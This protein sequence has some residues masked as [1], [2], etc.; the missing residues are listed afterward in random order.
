MTSTA[1]LISRGALPAARSCSGVTSTARAAVHCQWCSAP[2][3]AF[4][5]IWPSRHPRRLQSLF[6]PWA[7]QLLAVP[8]CRV[9]TGSCASACTDPHSRL[10]AAQAPFIAGTLRMVTPSTSAYMYRLVC[11]LA[12]PQHAGC[13]SSA[14]KPPRPPHQ[15]PPCSTHPVLPPVARQ[16]A[17]L[18]SPATSAMRWTALLSS[19]RCPLLCRAAA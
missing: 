17:P 5:S 9:L 1:W 11:S 2:H 10:S 3:S 6:G 18:P 16:P 8:S 4:N 19:S 13:R 12:P 7:G 15:P 14:P